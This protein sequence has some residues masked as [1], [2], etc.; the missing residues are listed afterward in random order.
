M[1]LSVLQTEQLASG[2]DQFQKYDIICKLYIFTVYHAQYTIS[3]SEDWPTGLIRQVFG[4]T[5]VR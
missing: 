2:L 1:E 4:Q 3:Q 5:W